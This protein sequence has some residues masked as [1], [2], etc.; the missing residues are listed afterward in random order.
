MP[1]PLPERPLAV[2]GAVRADMAESSVSVDLGLLK[3]EVGVTAQNEV[4]L[5]VGSDR[6]LLGQSAVPVDG[7]TEIKLNA[8]PQERLT[9]IAQNYP[10][11]ICLGK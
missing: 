10:H 11:Q 4:A 7:Q 3:G 6:Q 2:A 9:K 1:I 8:F 5:Q